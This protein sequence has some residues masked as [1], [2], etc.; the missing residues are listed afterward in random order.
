MRRISNPVNRMLTPKIVFI[1]VLYL[2][3]VF[4][5]KT[6]KTATEQRVVSLLFFRPNRREP[7]ISAEHEV[8]LAV[9]FWKNS[10]K[11]RELTRN[12]L[13]FFV[14]QAFGAPRS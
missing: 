3:S 5:L 7:T 11:Q 2:F 13:V 1:S 4:R 10:K 14:A 8:L 12:P 9:N 6:A